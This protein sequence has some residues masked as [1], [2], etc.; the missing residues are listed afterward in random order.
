MASKST[1]SGAY[2]ML[3]TQKDA[4]TRITGIITPESIDGLENKLG[5]AFTKLKSAH[6]AE[7]QPYGFLAT[8]IPQEKYPI[9][10]SNATWVY[11][12][13]GNPGAYAAAALA[14]GVSTAQ[15]DQLVAQHKEEQTAYAD[16]LGLQ[17]AGKELLLNGVGDDELAPLKKQCDSTI[18]SM[19]LHLRE[20]M[21]IKM[22]TS[23]KFE[24]KAEGYGKQWDPTTSITA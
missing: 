9:V 24:Y 10:I 3:V 14:P 5:G 7:G 1:K 4:I 21:A 11:T 16:Y 12:A 22:T 2:E 13:P 15:R 19:I 8:V 17:E 18:H 6:F 20:K 23:Q